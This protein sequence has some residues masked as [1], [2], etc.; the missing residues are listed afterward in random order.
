MK[1]VLSI[2]VA[3]YN[4]APYVR[5]CLQ[6]LLEQGLTNYEVILVNDA[7]HD[8]SRAICSEWCME[9]PQF[10]IV[11]HASNR[12]LSEA[13]NTGLAEAEGEYVTFVD[14]DDFLQAGTLGTCMQDIGDADVLEYPIMMDHL[15]REAHLWQ[16]DEG[17]TDFATWM[18]RVGFTHCYACNKVFRQRLWHSERF[19]S[20]LCYEDIVTIPRVMQ[21]AIRIKGTHQGIYYY[22]R[23]NGSISTTP[24]LKNLKDYAS[25]LAGLMA[26]PECSDNL[27]LYLRAL[28]AELSYRRAGGTSPVVPR[29]PIPM[30]YILG[31][32]LT[33]RQRAKAL[34]F[35]I[36]PTSR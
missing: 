14:S 16:P 1:P 21:K 26:L 20:G 9:H 23:R 30:S 32:G 19:P 13:R 6:S 18:R 34:W 10:R 31:P 33:L 35:K 22:C 36:K 25:A 5:H 28:N 12:G 2:I 3:V 7:S 15:T 29:K 8:N 17:V 24:S 4:V 11:N 27:N